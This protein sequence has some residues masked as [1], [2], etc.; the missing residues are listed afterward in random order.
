MRS[1]RPLY[2][3][4]KHREAHHYHSKRGDG[5]GIFHIGS[6]DFCLIG[7]WRPLCIIGPTRRRDFNHAG[8][9]R[10]E[11]EEASKRLLTM[12]ALP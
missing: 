1:A 2:D 10:Q 11:A 4:Q 12:P 7:K 6:N 5:Q 3:N 8:D 9:T